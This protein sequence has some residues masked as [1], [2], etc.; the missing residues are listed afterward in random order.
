M[1]ANPSVTLALS[2]LVRRVDH[3]TSPGQTSWPGDKEQM[4]NRIDPEFFLHAT[5]ALSGAL[6]TV[7]SGASPSAES[8]RATAERLAACLDDPSQLVAY[9]DSRVASAKAAAEAAAK[10]PQ[11]QQQNIRRAGELVDAAQKTRDNLAALLKSGKPITL[12][13]DL[14]F[15]FAVPRLTTTLITGA[16]GTDAQAFDVLATGFLYVAD[17]VT[18]HQAAT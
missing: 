4:S 16:G 15:A 1:L 2:R 11:P 14:A 9:F 5:A 10:V 7:N 18:A 3:E 8:V 13:R 17:L 12:V 6:S